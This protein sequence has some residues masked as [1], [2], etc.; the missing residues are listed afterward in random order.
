LS[1]TVS[2]GMAFSQHGPFELPAILLQADQAL[3]RAKK[4]G[5]N[6]LAIATPEMLVAAEQEPRSGSNVVR[7]GRRRAAQGPRALEDLALP[8]HAPARAAPF[9]PPRPRAVSG[10]GDLSKWMQQPP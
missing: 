6:R 9:C 3:Y 10:I 5:R 1:A 4:E 8:E 2:T 7:L